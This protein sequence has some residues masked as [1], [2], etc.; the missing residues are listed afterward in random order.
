MPI[1]STEIS[2]IIQSQVG[3]FSASAAYAQAVSAQYG[4]QSFGGMGV[5]DPRQTAY[6]AQ[7]GLQAGA[8]GT[9]MARAPGYGVA[10]MSGMAMMNF[11][12]RILDPFS[13]VANLGLQGFSRQGIGAAVGMGAMGVGA[14][15]GM[16][17]MA[18][19]ATDHMVAGAQNRGM[20]NSQ[21]SQMFPGMG[22]RGMGMM[23][24]QVEAQSRMG[25]GNLREITAV[26]QQ[27]VH[28]GAIDTQ[29]LTQFSQSF[30]KLMN[31]VR[32]VATVMNTS[33]QQAQQAMQSV[34]GMGVSGDQAAGFLGTMKSIGQAAN[35]S[36]QGMMGLAGAGAQF[37]RSTGI[38][39]MQAATGAMV[40]AGVYGYTERHGLIKGVTGAAQGRY[41]QAATRFLGSRQGKTVLGAMMTPGGQFDT[42]MAS[43]MASGNM[44][45]QEIQAAYNRNIS[46]GRQ[47]DM[48]NARGGE[49]AGQFISEF[50]PQAISGALRGASDQSQTPE[51]LRRALTGLNRNDLR[52]M[53][54]LASNTGQLRNKMLSEARAGF[55]EGQGPT[56]ISQII[57][58]AMDTLTKPIREK[59]QRMGANMTQYAQDA[60][61]DVTNQFVTGATNPGGISAM[62]MQGFNTGMS[63]L[64]QSGN[65]F[66]RNDWTTRMN[67]GSGMTGG[68]GWG[69]GE[70]AR[71]W[72]G[73][74]ANRFT[75]TGLRIGATSPGT[76]FS[77]LAGGGMGLPQYEPAQTALAGASWM[78]GFQGGRNIFGAAGAAT[79]WAGQG[80]TGAGP[81]MISGGARAGVFPGT[82]ATGPLGVGGL[83]GISGTG[84]MIGGGMRLGGLAMRG[85][86][87]VLGAAS[88]PLMAYDLVSNVGPANARR[89]GLAPNVTNA[90]TGDNA[91]LISNLGQMGILGDGALE[92][93]SPIT[94]PDGG[95]PL[96]GT[97]EAS[98]QAGVAGRQTFL[99]TAGQTSAENMM[100]TMN[101]GQMG[102]LYEKTPQ[103]KV[104]QW[105]KEIKGTGGA[106][107][108]HV[109][110]EKFMAKS[111]T[112]AQ[113]AYMLI[114]A[115]GGRGFEGALKGSLTGGNRNRR[116]PE[117]AMAFAQRR[118]TGLLE[119]NA[120]TGGA[121]LAGGGAFEQITANVLSQSGKGRDFSRAVARNR[122]L[123]QRG[124]TQTAI[125]LSGE[126]QDL[127]M[128]F[129][130][131]DPQKYA[132]ALL[133][134]QVGRDSAKPG[135][136]ALSQGTSITGY[137]DAEQFNVARQARLSK[138]RRDQGESGQNVAALRIA[139]MRGGYR[140]L[141]A[142]KGIQEKYERAFN[143]DGT[144][145][146]GDM[147][148][149][150]MQDFAK[151]FLSEGDEGGLS[152]SDDRARRTQT[153]LGKGG[154]ALSGDMAATMGAAMRYS[155]QWEQSKGS[156]AKFLAR[157]SHDPAFNNLTTKEKQFLRG[158]NAKGLTPRLEGMLEDTARDIMHAAGKNP[159]GAE[160]SQLADQIARGVATEGA[161]DDGYSVQDLVS[162]LAGQTTPVRPTTNRG[163]SANDAAT[164]VTDALSGFADNLE[165]I[166]QKLPSGGGW[167]VYWSSE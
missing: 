154:T 146:A 28:S 64:Q 23:A 44:S 71:G 160:A 17:A 111:G 148:S 129:G 62:Q 53:D 81:N 3:M 42:G 141:S 151:S 125:A 162:N 119:K 167:G 112:T 11:G 39:P 83:G 13:G 60:V 95:L 19:Y 47:R 104:Q 126:L 41:T 72:L 90:I 55:E 114:A 138:V 92:T 132:Q 77:D 31:N 84:R 161:T 67:M 86:G 93:T 79:S 54:M 29:T 135:S 70:P 24:G 139:A 50:G 10:A 157:V 96:A 116:S 7:A 137:D 102:Q 63:N 58:T 59:F 123:Y 15:M 99:T 1:T 105:L 134:D 78:R 150:A 32:N 159:T 66:A 124:D 76:S 74:A 144:I 166:V 127:G 147:E 153:A 57:S 46:G 40:S 163:G 109:L 87:A 131:S 34:S 145:V 133:D 73:R 43:Q 165:R 128:D 30:N 89:M 14:Y 136:T 4:Y 75:P 20:L 88:T 94:G 91:R 18:N 122:R 45:W 38:D 12:P 48:L 120:N 143:A 52:A 108:D 22:S 37:G 65:T 2:N 101:T 149:A 82:L 9:Q 140:K 164:R 80:I 69:G 49:I 35:I 110:L 100:R 16:G 8:I 142:F 61:E 97:F 85:A 51:T 107:E 68:F 25:M 118:L 152:I 121:T 98:G 155:K 21:M 156:P 6:G 36:P 130:G 5:N 115:E 103:G 117:E 33:L 113:D 27:G 26:M 158:T 56:S 106:P